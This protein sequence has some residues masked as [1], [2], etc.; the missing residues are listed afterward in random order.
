V[1]APQLTG[2]IFFPPRFIHSRLPCL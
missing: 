1:A 2:V